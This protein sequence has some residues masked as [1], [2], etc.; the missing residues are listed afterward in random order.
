MGV[1]IET[2]RLARVLGLFDPATM[3]MELAEEGV[4]VAGAH[5]EYVVPFE[6]VVNIVVV[7][8]FFWQ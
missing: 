5:R 6:D 2:S 7:G 8:R 3:S 1:R 4:R